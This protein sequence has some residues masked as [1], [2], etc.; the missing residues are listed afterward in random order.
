MNDPSF[1]GKLA[2][3]QRVLPAY[4]AAF[5]DKLAEACQGGLSV[6]AGLP[7]PGESIHTSDHLEIARL[8]PARNRNFGAVTSP[9]FLCWQSGILPWLE[10]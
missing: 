6:F 2:I 7:G 3:Q 4:R 5:F 10:S 8:V 9:F 1:P